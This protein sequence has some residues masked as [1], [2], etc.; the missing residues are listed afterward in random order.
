LLTARL[1]TNA[2]RS[3]GFQGRVFHLGRVVDAVGAEMASQFVFGEHL[4]LQVGAQNPP[5]PDEWHNA[6]LGEPGEPRIA[7][8][9]PVDPV[10]PRGNRADQ[11]NCFADRLVL[12]RQAVL[13][14]I[15]D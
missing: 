4:T 3:V 6:R 15:G 9:H 7:E 10:I 1:F 2:D 12:T 13:G 14:R 8:R 11:D 5:V